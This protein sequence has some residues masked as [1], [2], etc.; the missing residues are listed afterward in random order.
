MMACFSL[1]VSNSICNTVWK[2]PILCIDCLQAT[3]PSRF[4]NALL[5][6]K[7]L[8][9][10]Q[11]M[12]ECFSLTVINRS[13]KGSLIDTLNSQSN[14]P[15]IYPTHSVHQIVPPPSPEQKLYI[16]RPCLVGDTTECQ[17]LLHDTITTAKNSNALAI[18]CSRSFFLCDSFVEELI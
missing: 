16:T 3:K 5:R 18:C 4:G 12:M 1:T 10:N 2:L 13:V 11:S 15:Q 9:S 6:T 14:T 7:F 8:L 17:S